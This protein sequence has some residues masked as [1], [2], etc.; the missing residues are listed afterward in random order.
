MEKRLPT[1]PDAA[2]CLRQPWVG[3]FSTALQ[4]ALATPTPVTIS[5]SDVAQLIPLLAEVK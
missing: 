3:L 1:P 5:E 4:V 2:A